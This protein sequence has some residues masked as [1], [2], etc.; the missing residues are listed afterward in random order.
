MNIVRDS[1]QFVA[2]QADLA[3]DKI[4]LQRCLGA[5]CFAHF[6]GD[7]TKHFGRMPEYDSVR[8]PRNQQNVSLTS[9]GDTL[10]VERAVSFTGF[11]EVSQDKRMFSVER[12]SGE[13][14]VGVPW[15]EWS[16]SSD[17]GVQVLRPHSFMRR[18]LRRL[19][20]SSVDAGYT[21]TSVEKGAPTT[22]RKGDIVVVPSETGK[23]S[24]YRF[25][26]S[27]VGPKA[28]EEQ[29]K[30]YLPNAAGASVKLLEGQIVTLIHC[31]LPKSFKPARPMPQLPIGE[32]V[33][34][35]KKRG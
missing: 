25:E 5:A 16:L 7:M 2:Q 12:R 8:V 19:R 23:K 3:P 10:T 6:S 35:R 30:G 27:A 14:A 20:K 32:I 15:V 31:K 22:I 28:S 34:G 13:L 33:Q 29:S 1:T 11:V 18:C 24:C 17:T 4:L 9:S 21:I 26:V